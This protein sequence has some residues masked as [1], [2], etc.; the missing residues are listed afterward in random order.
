MK[1]KVYLSSWLSI[2][3]NSF[4]IISLNLL[5][6]FFML[7]LSNQSVYGRTINN[8]TGGIEISD[9]I[10]AF[11]VGFKMQTYKENQYIAYYD[12]EHNMVIAKRALNSKKWQ[13]TILPT[14]IGWDSHNYVTFDF[15]KNGYI[16]LSGNVHCIPLVYYRIEK[17]F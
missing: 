5:L 15:D 1:S 9:V 7:V 16:H 11:P 10:S 3:S 4:P 14:Q 17:D 6:A 12:S 8:L 13:K 2:L